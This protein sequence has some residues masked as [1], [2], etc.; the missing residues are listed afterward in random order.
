M[1]V[2][3]YVCTLF[4]LFWLTTCVTRRATLQICKSLEYVPAESDKETLLMIQCLCHTL[5]SSYR[6]VALD[7]LLSADHMY[8]CMIKRLNVCAYVVY[9]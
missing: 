1:Y 7:G 8:V 5:P 3:L 9:I 6:N 4:I 2:C